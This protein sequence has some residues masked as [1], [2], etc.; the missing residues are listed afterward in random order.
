MLARLNE[1]TT[2]GND[3]DP[4]STYWVSK[5]KAIPTGSPSIAE[6]ELVSVND[7]VIV[8]RAAVVV[9]VV[10][11]VIVVVADEDGKLDDDVVVELNEDD[12]R[13]VVVI[14][15]NVSQSSLRAFVATYGSAG[16]RC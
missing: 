10:V 8:C 14:Y 9:V 13:L 15:W 2:A 16:G 4:S 5:S 12:E 6:P 3:S 1:L 11:V 7:P